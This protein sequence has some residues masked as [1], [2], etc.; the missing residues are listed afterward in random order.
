MEGGS[1]WTGEVVW[2]IG[3]EDGGGQTERERKERNEKTSY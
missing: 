3:D 1:E 2:G